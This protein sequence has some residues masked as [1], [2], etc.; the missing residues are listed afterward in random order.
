MV[1]G[2]G[3]RVVEVE[4]CVGERILVGEGESTAV[5]VEVGDCSVGEGEGLGEEVGLGEV[6]MAE[7]TDGAGVGPAETG[8][9]VLVG[10]EE[11]EEG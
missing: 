7:G 2:V 8:E 1:D 9:G 3:G 6:G 10:G 11:G 5:G 4:A